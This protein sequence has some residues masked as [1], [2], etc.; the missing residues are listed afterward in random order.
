MFGIVIN[1]DGFKIAFVTLDDI[2][3]PLYY[4]LS[5]GEL[6]IEQDWN[7]ANAMLKPQWIGTEWIET[8][9]EEELAEAFPSPLPSQPTSEER[10]QSLE[11][12]MLF[13]TLGGM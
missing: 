3:K 4:N 1:K 9:T 2:K 7:I 13:L 6:I 10:L 8:A 5:D 12:A 11:D